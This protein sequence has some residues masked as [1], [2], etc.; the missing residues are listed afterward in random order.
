MHF[1][2]T[3]NLGYLE[4]RFGPFRTSV[5]LPHV[6]GS[7]AVRLRWNNPGT[8]YVSSGLMLSL[9]LWKFFC[10]TARY[11]TS[12]HLLGVSMYA[13]QNGPRE[14]GK[15]GRPLRC[16]PGAPRSGPSPRLQERRNNRHIRPRVQ[17]QLCYE[18][19]DLR[20]SR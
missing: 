20:S 12:C 9:S 11:S 13:V 5:A 8:I 15:W 19:A 7:H 6:Y 2:P 1:V 3:R 4:T 16:S 17:S 18:P 14:A 10:S